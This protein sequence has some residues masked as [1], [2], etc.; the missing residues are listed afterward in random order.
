MG[1]SNW[2]MESTA[3]YRYEL[4]TAFK[5]VERPK[6]PCLVLTGFLGSGKTTLLE[7]ILK[8]KSNLRIGAVVNDAADLNIDR[9]IVERT[10]DSAS[11]SEVL[12]LSNGCLC[13][14]RSAD[15]S[16][17]DAVRQLL[18]KDEASQ[19]SWLDYLVVETSGVSDPAPLVAALDQKFGV[20]HKVRLDSVVAMVDSSLVLDQMAAGEA[21]DLTLHRQLEWADTIILNKQDLIPEAQ[22]QQLQQWCAQLN[23]SARQVAS[24]MARVPLPE[25]LD[26]SVA[27]DGANDRIGKEMRIGAPVWQVVP[28]CHR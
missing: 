16:F 15:G 4:R 3:C 22:R 5:P 8:N 6:L 24:V 28:R 2:A 9:M 26:V 12:G 14:S 27:E 17:A 21:V 10:I 20:M 25:L 23:P 11:N 18:Q 13:C 1:N 7:H 19:G